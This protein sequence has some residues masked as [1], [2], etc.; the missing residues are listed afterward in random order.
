M[1]FMRPLSVTILAC[2]YIAVGSAGFVY[3]LSDF[4]G[5]DPSDAALVELTELLAV[6]SGIFLLKGRN[7]ARWGALAWIGFHVVRS[8]F[9]S[10][11][12]VAVH[13]LFLGA[14]AWILF[15]PAAAASFTSARP[16]SQNPE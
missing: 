13:A 6:L 11:Q 14:I 2:V 15:R 12:Q 8:A 16:Y 1:E 5:Q 3:H 10:M 4:R 9:H 7:W